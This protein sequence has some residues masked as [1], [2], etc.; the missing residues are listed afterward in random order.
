MIFVI[1]EHRDNKLKPITSEL[2]A[3]AQ[4]V[5]RDFS[6]PITAVVLGSDSAA[7]VNELKAKK[8]DRVLSLIH[9]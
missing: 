2:L 9:I 4:H 8:I 7:L 3:F 6:Q 5:G 1:A